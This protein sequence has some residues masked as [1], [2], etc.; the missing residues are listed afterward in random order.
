MNTLD[1]IIRALE[2]A[3]AAGALVAY[4]RARL[5]AMSQQLERH[6]RELRLLRREVRRRTYLL[7][8]QLANGRVAAVPDTP[9][10]Q[11]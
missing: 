6:D 7:V 10:K 3:F 4:I 5:D 11:P 8:A 2:L 9:P 1:L